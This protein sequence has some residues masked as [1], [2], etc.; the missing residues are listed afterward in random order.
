MVSPSSFPDGHAD[1]N[2]RKLEISEKALTRI[3][4]AQFCTRWKGSG[5]QRRESCQRREY[6]ACTYAVPPGDQGNGNAVGEDAAH[7]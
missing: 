3:F 4:P 7:G 6:K 2:G 5:G 1:G